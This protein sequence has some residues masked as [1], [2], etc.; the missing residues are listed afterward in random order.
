MSDHDYYMREA[1]QEALL[2]QS[3]GGIPIGSVLVRNGNIIG[4]GHNRRV[5]QGNA[6]LHAEIDCLMNAGRQ[7]TYRDTTLYSTLCPCYLCSGA[8]VQF[9]IPRVIV[10]E[11]VNFPGAP[12]FLRQQGVEVTD[13]RVQ[14]LVDVMA[15]FIQK[16]PTL[17]AE[18]IAE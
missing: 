4:R 8:V 14:Q 3:E 13:L 9:K 6:I 18:D 2:G 16:N 11:S 7:R 10:G 12:D 15:S 5:Q 1:I 17:W